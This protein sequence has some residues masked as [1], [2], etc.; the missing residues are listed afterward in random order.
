MLNRE[1]FFLAAALAGSF[2]FILMFVAAGRGLAAGEFTE[3]FLH[4]PAVIEQGKAVWNKRCKFCHGKTAYP[5]KAPRLD[6]SRYQPE[7]VFDRVTNG[8][9]GMPSMK[10]EFN[11]EQRRAVTAYIMSDEFS[12]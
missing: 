5:G 11:D 4:D 10:T 6:P 12:N 2:G 3:Q 1:R 9:K 8:F 7:F